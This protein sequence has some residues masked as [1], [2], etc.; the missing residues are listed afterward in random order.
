M[1]VS[2]SKE[3]NMFITEQIY[4]KKQVKNYG[5][6]DPVSIYDK[7]T[8]VPSQDYKFLKLSHQ[9]HSSYQKS[10]IERRIKYIKVDQKM[11]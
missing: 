2:R 4:S 1:G 9:I 10:I 8:L 5:P 11:F 3:P 6:P 7:R